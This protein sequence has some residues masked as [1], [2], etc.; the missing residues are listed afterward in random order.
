M[1]LYDFKKKPALTTKEG[2]KEVLYPSIVY[3]GKI[4]T[5]ELLNEL[6][7]RSTF[8]AGEIEGALM[9]LV[10]LVGDYLGRGYHVELGDFGVFSGKI[11]SR[12]VA[13][14]KD[15]RSRSIYFNGVNFRASKEFR[16][17]VSGELERS[18][19]L[20]FRKSR[21]LPEEE[22]QRRLLNH[23]DQ[24]GFINRTTYTQITGRLKDVALADLKKFVQQGLIQS[25]GRGNQLHFIKTKEENK[26]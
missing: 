11:K 12:M 13:D 20:K 17:K 5:R 19:V 6:A 3:T 14:K 21:Q 4:G 22:L 18:R 24:H 23:L 25:M 10:K 2:E 15:I 7:G 16:A 1:A 26:Q 8:Q 9:E